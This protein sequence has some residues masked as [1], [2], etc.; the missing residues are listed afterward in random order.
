[1]E[2]NEKS[3]IRDYENFLIRIIK[4]FNINIKKFDEY[5]INSNIE[6]NL[7]RKLKFLDEIGGS[8]QE[9][10]K[11]TY[12]DYKIEYD[13]SFPLLLNPMEMAKRLN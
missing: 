1:M 13:T 5:E 11:E 10:L 6:K 2:S 3:N 7:K 9:I 12:L 8:Y 4:N